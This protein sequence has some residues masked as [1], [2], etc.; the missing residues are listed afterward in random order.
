MRFSF[1]SSSCVL[2]PFRCRRSCYCSMF[3]TKT[4][5]F[6]GLTEFIEVVRGFFSTFLECLLLLP[7]CLSGQAERLDPSAGEPLFPDSRVIARRGRASSFSSIHSFFLVAAQD[8]SLFPRFSFRERAVRSLVISN[9]T[10][11]PPKL[12][13]AS[14]TVD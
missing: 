1:S 14:R 13:V 3:H 7:S 8:R 5:L 6:R 10:L 12:S 4:G 9:G 11:L 2:F